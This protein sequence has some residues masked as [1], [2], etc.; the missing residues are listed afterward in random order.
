MEIVLGG[1]F[2]TALVRFTDAI[3]RPERNRTGHP[4]YL[5][6]NRTIPK[7]F[8]DRAATFMAL[9]DEVIV[10]SIDWAA[11]SATEP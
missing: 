9:A 5:C 1:Y 7:A 3:V 4:Y 2:E 8:F 10:P 11:P 6:L